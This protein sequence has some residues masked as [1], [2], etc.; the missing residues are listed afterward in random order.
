MSAFQYMN[1]TIEAWSFLFCILS[2]IVILTGIYGARQMKQY[3]LSLFICLGLVFFADILI[4]VF[5]FFPNGAPAVLYIMAFAEKLFGY[6]FSFVFLC[7]LL[8]LIRFSSGKEMET[9]KRRMLFAGSVIFAGAVLLLCVSQVTGILYFFDENGRC[10]MGS[11]W[12]L[13]LFFVFAF[14]AADIFLLLRFSG[15]FTAKILIFLYFCIIFPLGALILQFYIP[16][17]RL[18]HFSCTL[19]ALALLVFLFHLQ[20][21]KYMLS[22]Q[23]VTD[24]QTAVMLS[25]IQPHFLYN[26]LSSIAWL[27]EKDPRTAK[28]ATIAFAEYLRGNMDS[29]KEKNPIPFTR[30]LDHLKHYLYLEKMRFGDCLD[31]VLDIQA[32]N[33]KIPVLS[34]QPLVEN[35]IRHGVSM[36]EEGGRI[37]IFSR[38]LPRYFEI[39]IIDNGFGFDPAA[40]DPDSKKH[41]G[42]KNVQSRLKT[43][44]NGTLSI[45]STPGAGTAVTI[46]IP[47]EVSF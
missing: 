3:L 44:C 42:I 28:N 6:I 21:E 7:F 1:I 10:Y 31:I 23:K 36:K 39:R 33:F 15:V 18:V 2:V 4:I 20:T 29:L 46:T 11:L 9:L 41:I 13:S 19:A 34:L 35:A 5:P 38:E 26:S 25:Q 47:K 32:V 12:F 40:S 22:E 27:C 30:E 8:Y 14:L 37:T 17:L 45:N 43:M 24:M 16:Q